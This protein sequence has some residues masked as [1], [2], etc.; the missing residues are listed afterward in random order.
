MTDLWFWKMTHIWTLNA[1]IFLFVLLFLFLDYKCFITNLCIYVTQYY[2]FM[3]MIS[4]RKPLPFDMWHSIATSNDIL[5]KNRKNIRFMY[6]VCMTLKHEEEITWTT[7]A[8]T[9]YVLYA[10]KCLWIRTSWGTYVKLSDTTKQSA[11]NR[12]LKCSL[13]QPPPP[14]SWGP[15]FL[16]LGSKARIWCSHP[17]EL[18]IDSFSNFEFHS[19]TTANAIW[20]SF[21]PIFPF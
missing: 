18:N 14:V 17:F 16:H 11:K 2:I 8:S 6:Y 4:R 12:W 10:F 3:H 5:Q 19:F 13:H 1:Y 21:T 20:L 9:Q 7:G 15:S